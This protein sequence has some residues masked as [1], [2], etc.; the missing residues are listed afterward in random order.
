MKIIWFSE[1]KWNYLKTRKQQILIQ[2]PKSSSIYF[3]EPISRILP[4]HFTFRTFNNIKAIT[5]PQTRTINGIFLNS[6]LSISFVQKIINAIANLW[7]NVLFIR[8]TSS[9][10]CIITSNVFWVK[11]IS[12][13]KNK[14]PNIPII[15]DC[16]DNPLAFPG[17]PDY[18][19]DYFIETLNIADRVIIP[20]A[21]YTEF[22][23]ENYRSKIAIISNGVDYQLF[24]KPTETPSSLENIK[25]PIIM[26]IGTI[27]EWFNF[28]LIEEAAKLTQYNFVLVGPVNPIVDNQVKRLNTIDNILFMPAIPHEEIPNY[29]KK[30]N[31]CIIPFI[32]NRLTKSVLPNK[33]FEY[34][35]AGKSCVLTEF[36]SNLFDFSNYV[37]IASDYDSFINEIVRLVKEP[38]DPTHMRIFSKEYD[39]KN[40]GY[41]Y[42]EMLKEI[43]SSYSIR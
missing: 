34:A 16:N 11:T 8:Q 3:I 37:S 19:K 39:W 42:Y 13:L 14:R 4:N 7:F 26:Y 22:I 10:D 21:G 27:S 23:P 29:I 28:R 17:T 20:H 31:A 12:R 15:Y 5:I 25:N 40:I 43:V 2:F 24:Q 9:V 18:K 1:I 33:M 38:L 35:A 32:K 41:R 6:I 30:A 36:N